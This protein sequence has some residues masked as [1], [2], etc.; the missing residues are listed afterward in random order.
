[1][2]YN[3]FSNFL[4]FNHPSHYS[5]DWSVSWKILLPSSESA[6]DSTL[7]FFLFLSDILM[8]LTVF[9]CFFR[10]LDFSGHNLICSIQNCCQR[11]STFFTIT[12]VLVLEGVRCYWLAPR[13]TITNI[14]VIHWSI[15]V[16]WTSRLRWRSWRI[17]IMRTSG[18]RRW[19]MIEG[20]RHSLEIVVGWHQILVGKI[21]LKIC[22]A[23]PLMQFG[24]LEL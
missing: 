19:L 15:R 12:V 2:R 1:M 10:K 20:H 14:C 24:L 4:F 23:L 16:M 6:D 22:Y 18:L 9:L 21:G 13:C 8:A 7:P 5:A 11:P 3:F 17:R